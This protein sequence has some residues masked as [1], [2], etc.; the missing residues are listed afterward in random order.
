MTRTKHLMGE[1]ILTTTLPI[2]LEDTMMRATLYRFDEIQDN[3][4]LEI[5]EKILPKRDSMVEQFSSKLKNST[6]W[7][8]HKLYCDVPGNH[9]ILGFR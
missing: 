4:W 9:K 7:A 3:E 8:T 1:K 6:P 5:N 2:N